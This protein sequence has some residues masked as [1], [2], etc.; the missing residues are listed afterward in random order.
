MAADLRFLHPNLLKRQLSRN[1]ERAPNRKRR[2]FL[3][4]VP[5]SEIVNGVLRAFL[6]LLSACAHD[7]AEYQH[8]FCGRNLRGERDDAMRLTIHARHFGRIR[9]LEGEWVRLHLK[10][11]DAH[12]PLKIRSLMQFRGVPELGW[13]RCRGAAQTDTESVQ[14]AQGLRAELEDVVDAWLDWIGDEFEYEFQHADPMSL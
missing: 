2:Q 11:D 10:V 4:D 5:Y 9:D 14:R 6:P 7:A 8:H 13:I 1:A 12:G 3:C